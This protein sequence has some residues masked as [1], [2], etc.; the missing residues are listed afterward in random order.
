M[1]PELGF[2][3]VEVGWLEWVLMF[4]YS[5]FQLPGGVIGQR[6]GARSTYVVIGLLAFAATVLGHWRR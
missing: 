1:M 2:S 6:L 4:G 3:Q 5:A